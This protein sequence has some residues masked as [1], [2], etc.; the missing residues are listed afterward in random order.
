MSDY[1][2]LHAHRTH[3]LPFLKHIIAF[4]ISVSLTMQNPMPKMSSTLLP[5]PQ[6]LTLR[7]QIQ[8]LLILKV[9][10]DSRYHLSFLWALTSMWCML[11]LKDHSAL[12]TGPS[13][14]VQSSLLLIAVFL[15]PNSN[16]VATK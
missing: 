2:V 7:G 14:E 4:P 16:I 8:T 9:F 11:L 5:C 6:I 13:P 12:F 1:P 15:M 3:A 10:L